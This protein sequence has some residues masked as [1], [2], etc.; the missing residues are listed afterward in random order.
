MMKTQI[1]VD[2]RVG[3]VSIQRRPSWLLQHMRAACAVA[4]GVY[5]VLG[6]KP[7]FADNVQPGIDLFM[8]PAGSQAG[9]F[10]AGLCFPD[11]IPVMPLM[12]DPFPGQFFDTVVERLEQAVLPGIPSQDTIPIVIRAL[13]LVSVSPVLIGA[14]SFDVRVCLSDAPQAMGTMTIR[15][16]CPDGGTFDSVLPVKPKL[17]FTPVGGGPT[18]TCDIGTLAVPVDELVGT[19][20]EWVHSAEVAPVIRVGPGLQVDGNC[21]DAADPPLPGTTNFVASL[22]EESCTPTSPPGPA[23]PQ[24]K[25]L[26]GEEAD[27]VRHGVMVANPPPPP[28]PALPGWAGVAL[29]AVLFVAGIFVFGKRRTETQKG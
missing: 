3:A 26:T 2:E 18:T 4:A 29:A 20:A 5:A 12:G 14:Q 25:V 6:A 17:I 7:G 24:M 22:G 21:D 11:A 19:G 9:P 27:F 28:V 13:S 15:H 16:E 1:K 8:T 23:S 10:P